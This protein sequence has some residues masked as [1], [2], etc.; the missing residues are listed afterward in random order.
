MFKADRDNDIRLSREREHSQIR[1]TRDYLKKFNK[2]VATTATTG[3]AATTT[4]T[5]TVTTAAAAAVA[6]ST[7]NKLDVQPVNDQSVVKSSDV[8]IEMSVPNTLKPTDIRDNETLAK[9][10]MR[11]DCRYD[12]WM[13]KCQTNDEIVLLQC[14]NGWFKARSRDGKKRGYIISRHVQP[15][16]GVTRIDRLPGYDS[17]KQFAD[18][19]TAT[20]VADYEGFKKVTTC[21]D[22]VS[23]P[24]LTC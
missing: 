6:T 17:S 7:D 9:V 4:A 23:V 22:V 20:M 19:L 24:M 1:E 13:L 12:M 5:A 3:T 15:I 2:E 11:I 10:K 16:P 21:N 8:V 18:Q 14:Y